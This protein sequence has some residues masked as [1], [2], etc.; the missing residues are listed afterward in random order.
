M[1]IHERYRGEYSPNPF[2][3][4]VLGENWGRGGREK[5]GHEQE[6]S[7]RAPRAVG[8]LPVIPVKV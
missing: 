4:S 7:H 3:V 8:R 6:S 2:E 5:D 1:P